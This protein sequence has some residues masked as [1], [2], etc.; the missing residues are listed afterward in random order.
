MKNNIA[1]CA[2]AVFQCHEV[3]VSDN[4]GYILCSILKRYN[5]LN[6]Y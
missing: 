5:H 6:K 3:I 1:A 4:S 2:G